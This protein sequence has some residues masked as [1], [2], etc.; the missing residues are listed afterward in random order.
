MSSLPE[1]SLLLLPLI[2]SK[3]LLLLL[4]LIFRG[5]QPKF[6]ALFINLET[7]I[8][9]EWLQTGDQREH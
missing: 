1:L 2:S 8:I 4:F 6:M 9:K 7:K 5:K 3:T